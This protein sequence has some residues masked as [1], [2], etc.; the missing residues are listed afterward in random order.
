VG[1]LRV[2]FP[3]MDQEFEWVRGATSGCDLDLSV[4]VSS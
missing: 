4:L 2:L 3:K 1:N